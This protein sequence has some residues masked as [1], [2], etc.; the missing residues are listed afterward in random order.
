MS[1]H[2]IQRQWLLEIGRQ[3]RDGATGVRLI[4]VAEE[5]G[6]SVSPQ[7]ANR[8]WR[9]VW[10]HLEAMGLVRDVHHSSREANFVDRVTLTDWGS[11][12]ANWDD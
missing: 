1:D 10:Y 2:G 9:E 5:T 8:L 7:D 11:D 3:L 4:D 12:P 6:V